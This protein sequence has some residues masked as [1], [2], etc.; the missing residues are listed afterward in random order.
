MAFWLTVPPTLATDWRGQTRGAYLEGIYRINRSWDTGYR[1]DRLWADDQGPFA[2]AH[3]PVRNSLMLTWRNSE[4]SL[5]RLQF[6]RD[7]PNADD[8]DNVFTLQYQT[9][10]G[11]HGAHKF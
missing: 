8:I 3:D 2:S 7:E 6:S 1:Y 5:I 11:A 9:S 4:F 10:L